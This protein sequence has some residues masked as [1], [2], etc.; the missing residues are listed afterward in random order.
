MAS[1][2]IIAIAPWK[3]STAKA[4]LKKLLEEDHDRNIIHGMSPEAVYRLS[5]LFQQYKLANFKTN[6]KNLKESIAKESRIA[7]FHQQ[8]FENDRRLVPMKNK[9]GGGYPRFDIH[10]SK[11]LLALDVQE[12]KHMSVKPKMLQL[13]RA[14]YQEL[15]LKVFRKH[16]YQ[17]EYALEGR[18]YWMHKKKLN[19][20]N[21]SRLRNRRDAN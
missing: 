16:I 13:T 2:N 6:L 5:P 14:E 9:A 21:K 20:D 17:E 12:K 3:N 10:P 15:P 7:T 1:N 4:E 19:D 8:A 11:G 18:S